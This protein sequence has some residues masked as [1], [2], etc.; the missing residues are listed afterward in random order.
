[1]TE[2]DRT[3]SDLSKR[4]IFLGT[5]G[6]FLF[7]LFCSCS[8][9]PA[10][11]LRRTCAT[12]PAPYVLTPVS[13]ARPRIAAP[14]VGSIGVG[15]GDGEGKGVARSVVKTRPRGDQH[16]PSPWHTACVPFKPRRPSLLPH[17]TCVSPSSK[18]PLTFSARS[19]ARR[20]DRRSGALQRRFMTEYDR[21]CF[22]SVQNKRKRGGLFFH[23]LFF[24]VGVGACVGGTPMHIPSITN[25]QA[26]FMSQIR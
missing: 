15:V 9:R 24:W 17:H 19:A 3:C 21:T 14:V 4:K 8:R 16:R 1:M 6:A 5:K 13:D 25:G 20:S 12:T 26:R 2:H 11:C 23:A 7:T 22:R 10:V 18:H